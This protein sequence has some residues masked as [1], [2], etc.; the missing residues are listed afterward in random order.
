MG[1]VPD[2]LRLF[3]DLIRVEAEL[4]GAAEV[5]L[6]TDCQRDR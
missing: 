5:R 3:S 4:S 1:G 2:L 6:R